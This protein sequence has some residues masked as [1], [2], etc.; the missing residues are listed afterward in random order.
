MISKFFKCHNFCYL[1]IHKKGRRRLMSVYETAPDSFLNLNDI[2][3]DFTQY[4][5]H[6]PNLTISFF[7]MFPFSKHSYDRPC[8]VRAN[9]SCR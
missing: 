7:Q 1:G 9:S 2:L 3:S 8:S 4:T 6:W 5:L